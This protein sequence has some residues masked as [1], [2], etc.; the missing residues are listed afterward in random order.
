MTELDKIQAPILEEMKK[1]EPFFR[2]S[3]K[4]NVSLLD[5]ITRYI[6]KRKGKQMRPMLVFLSAK[7]VGEVNDSTYNAASLIELM[8]T[9]TL[10][11]DDVVDDSNKRRGFFS[12]NA[13]WKNKAAVLIGDYLLSRGLLLAVEKKEFELLQIVS[14]AVRDM[15]EGEL[16]QIEKSRK[17][18]ISEE[19]YFSIIRKKT[20]ALIASC[21]ATGSRSAG[22]SDDIVNQ[23]KSFGE[24]LGIAFQMKDD[25]FDYNLNGEAGKPI[26]NDIKEKKMTLPLIYALRNSGSSDKSTILKII[27]SKNKKPSKIKEV[28]RFVREKGGIDYT[29]ETMNIYKEKALAILSSFADN[30]AKKSLTDLVNYTIERNK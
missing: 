4:S 27:R 3:M 7:L 17:L 21:A 18:D 1:F 13:L 19:V 23:L 30:E 22:A 8:H 5:I 12:I 29:K 24:N 28:Q 16:L 2:N 11:H 15:S 25:L 10:I 6:L 20:A 26:G 9:A 14:E